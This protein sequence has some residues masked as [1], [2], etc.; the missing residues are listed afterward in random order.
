MNEPKLLPAPRTFIVHGVV[1]TTGVRYDV[2]T[3]ETWFKTPFQA[4]PF[5]LSTDCE[6]TAKEACKRLNLSTC[7]VFRPMRRTPALV[8]TTTLS[9]HLDM[10]RERYYERNPHGLW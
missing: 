1:T 2:R 7:P 4:V 9:A 10:A 8:P 6:E 3:L 5:V